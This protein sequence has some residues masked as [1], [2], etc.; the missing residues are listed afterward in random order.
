MSHFLNIGYTG[1][2]QE[3]RNNRRLQ[4]K[5]EKTIKRRGEIPAQTSKTKL[6]MQSTLEFNKYY[7]NIKM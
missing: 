1:S 5:I 7:E 6:G 3:I 4:D 2:P